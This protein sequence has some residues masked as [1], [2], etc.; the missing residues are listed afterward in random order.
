MHP[1]QSGLMV[2]GNLVWDHDPDESFCK[3]LCYD[4]KHIFICGGKKAKRARR[5]HTAGI[6][7]VLDRNTYELVKTI[8]HEKIRGLRGALVI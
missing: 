1:N 3:G 5:K 4:E 7:Y 2:D 8:E 6:I